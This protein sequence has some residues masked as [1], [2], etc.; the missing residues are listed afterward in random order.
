MNNIFIN[1]IKKFYISEKKN[2]FGIY[3]PA[4]YGFNLNMWSETKAEDLRSSLNRL[5]KI[6]LSKS[7]NE[8]LEAILFS[9]SYPPKGMKE[10]EF[11]EL[12]VNWLIRNDRSKLIEDFL[13]QN[14]SY[15]WQLMEYC[16]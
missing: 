1:I 8:I 10:D 9:F 14:G 2:V 16:V 15:W 5:K 12:K 3:E 7:S 11:V 13:K 4:S 6:E